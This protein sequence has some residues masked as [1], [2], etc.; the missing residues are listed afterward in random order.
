LFVLQ[1]LIAECKTKTKNSKYDDILERKHIHE[2][3]VIVQN[4]Y[5]AISE[6]PIL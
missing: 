3:C 2:S 6:A 5:T 4:I 1:P